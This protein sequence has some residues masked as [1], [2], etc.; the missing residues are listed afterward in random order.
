MQYQ[1]I[2]YSADNEHCDT[3]YFLDSVDCIEWAKQRKDWAHKFEV[4]TEEW[5]YHLEGKVV[6]STIKWEQVSK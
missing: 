4:H 5:D 1:V 3:D 2:A 6:G